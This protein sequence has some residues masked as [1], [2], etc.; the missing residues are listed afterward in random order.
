MTIFF[1]TRTAARAF[2]S[3]NGYVVDNGKDAVAGRRWGF[4]I[5][6]NGRN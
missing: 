1:A 2:T 4:R 5:S 3:K 6:K